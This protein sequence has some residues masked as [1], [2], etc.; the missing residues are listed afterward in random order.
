VISGVHPPARDV[1][2][3]RYDSSSARWITCARPE[4]AGNY[5]QFSLG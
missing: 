2:W 5:C 1:A 4:S 3:Y